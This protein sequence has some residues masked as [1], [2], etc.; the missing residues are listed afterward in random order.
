MKSVFDFGDNP[1][2]LVCGLH[3]LALQS[4]PKSDFGVLDHGL[5]Y[6]SEMICCLGFVPLNDVEGTQQ[7]YG[8][9]DEIP[10]I[11]PSHGI[12][13]TNFSRS[14]KRLPI[15]DFVYTD[16]IASQRKTY[17]SANT[18]KT[19]YYPTEGYIVLDLPVSYASEMKSV[20]E[21]VVGLIMQDRNVVSISGDNA[22][23]KNIKS[24]R[25][26][27]IS[28]QTLS[29]KLDA[30]SASQCVIGN[31]YV[32]SIVQRFMQGKLVFRMGFRPE[33]HPPL[34]NTVNLKIG[35]KPLPEY[36]SYNTLP[37]DEN[38][39]C[40]AIARIIRSFLDSEDFNF[41]LP[42]GRRVFLRSILKKLKH[43]SEDKHSLS[44]IM[45]RRTTMAEAIKAA[46]NDAGDLVEIGCTRQANDFSAGYSTP[47]LT[48]VANAIQKTLYSVDI[49][50]SN[51]QTAIFLTKDIGWPNKSPLE[52]R[53]MSGEDFLRVNSG[54]KYSL[55]YL[56]G[57]DVGI[58][59]YQESTLDQAI[60]A[61][62]MT[63]NILIDDTYHDTYSNSWVG[64]GAKAVPWLLQAGFFVKST[65]Y[66]VFLQKK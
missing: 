3:F 31:G 23:L 52:T 5:G 4:R 2:N 36:F 44:P 45:N 34:V 28:D 22:Y 58:P 30:I 62:N 50:F 9:Y 1:H 14:L 48:Y 6:L 42:P 10:K 66:Q 33:L 57:A 15:P 32:T 20:Y 7:I 19:M 24:S 39:D 61:S 46:A 21:L 55:I 35:E 12:I 8:V 51:I 63:G 26:T 17:F 27:D 41:H 16:K 53:H 43:L 64:K 59:S 56:D 65:G 49:T 40:K 38:E 47:I 54:Q 11:E 60:L 18:S 37:I 13:E 29:Q 25:L